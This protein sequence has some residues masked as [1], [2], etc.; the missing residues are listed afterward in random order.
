[1]E[2]DEAFQQDLAAGDVL[3]LQVGDAEG[4]LEEEQ[5]E[6]EVRHNQCS[7]FIDVLGNSTD[8]WY[9]DAHF[10][11]SLDIYMRIVGNYRFLQNV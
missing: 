9:D 8:N 4:K 10:V 2:E 1:M 11:D 3:Q 7:C 6:I 5:K